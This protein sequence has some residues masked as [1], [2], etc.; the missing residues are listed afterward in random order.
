MRFH[1]STRWMEKDKYKI[2]ERKKMIAWDLVLFFLAVL[3]FLFIGFWFIISTLDVMATLPGD[4]VTLTL[5]MEQRISDARG[6]FVVFLF[7]V[8]G[9][10]SLFLITGYFNGTKQ[11][12][13]YEAL[14]E[15]NAIELQF[16]RTR[17]Q[18]I[19]DFLVW[20]AQQLGREL[21]DSEKQDIAEKIERAEIFDNGEIVKELVEFADFCYRKMAEK[22]GND[23]PSDSAESTQLQ[24]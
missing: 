4:G 2:K 24:R 3:S 21:A 22:A 9:N 10:L 18:W 15:M 8:A 5:Q 14:G 16:R 20:K 7:V 6:L 12:E 1:G 19:P 13:K 11:A 23:A 17:Q